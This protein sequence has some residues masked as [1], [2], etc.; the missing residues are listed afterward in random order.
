MPSIERRLAD[1]FWDLR[2]DPYD[3]PGRRRG[4]TPEDLFQRLAEWVEDAEGRG[5]EVDWDDVSRRLLAWR[6]TDTAN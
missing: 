2:D 3:H 6:S 1:A 5:V 4:V